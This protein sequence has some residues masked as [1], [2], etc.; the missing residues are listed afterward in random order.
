MELTYTAIIRQGGVD[1][2]HCRDQRTR[3]T[4]PKWHGPRLPGF[5]LHA[6]P[7]AHHAVLAHTESRILE[8][9]ARFAGFQF[10]SQI[11][12]IGYNLVISPA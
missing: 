5:F 8:W 12:E 4:A 7:R 2:E 6:E 10:A 9:H 1:P 11:V 3:V